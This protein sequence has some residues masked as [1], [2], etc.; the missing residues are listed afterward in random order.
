MA[1]NNQISIIPKDKNL[2]NPTSKVKQDLPSYW[3]RDFIHECLNNIEKP[4]D[5]MICSF[6]WFTGC[7]ITE[8]VSLQKQ[9][10]NF[11]D[12]LIT[13]RWLKSRKYNYRVIPMHPHLKGLL[14][15]YT[16]T[17]K[18]EQTLFP[19]TRQRAWQIIQKYFKGHPHQLRH[20]FAVN[21]L[22]CGGDIVTLS[23][24][25]GHSDIKVT[26]VYLRIVPQDIGKEL[27]KIEF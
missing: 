7:R 15:I 18:A 6:M 27:L 10:L 11:K 12:H 14:E 21:W 16:G 26:M 19:I 23:R 4:C 3:D 1:D 8:V 5:K 20:S 17:M 9:S 22:K 24:M 13:I 2:T 25:L